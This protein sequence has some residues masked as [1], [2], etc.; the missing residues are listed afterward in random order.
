MAESNRH[1]LIIGNSQ[2]RD[3]TLRQLVTPRL[4]AQTLAHVLQDPAIGDFQVEILLDQESYPL[5]LAIERFFVRS[6]PADTLLLY[7][8]GHGVLDDF[9]R[10]LYLA[11]R[12][13][14]REYLN[15]TS[16]PSG[17]I[18]QMMQKS[19]A[20]QKILILDSCYSGA[21]T[22]EML[23]KGT[24]EIAGVIGSQ[25]GRGV[26]ILTASTALQYAFEGT[27]IEELTQGVQSLFTRFL[28][29]GLK[30]GE[31]AWGDKPFITINDLFRYAETH[32]KRAQV[33]QTPRITAIEQ[34]GDIIIAK[35][36]K[37]RQV[38]LPSG[39]LRMLRS[40]VRANRL[41][42]VDDLIQLAKGEDKA[43][44]SLAIEKLK[45]L[46]LLEDDFVVQ[47]T[48]KGGLTEIGAQPPEIPV[49]CFSSGEQP[50][51]VNDWV[52]LADQHWHEAREF[53]YNGTL[54]KWLAH[55]NQAKLAQ[56][57]GSM[58]KT[59]KDRSLG[60]EHFLRSTGLVKPQSKRDT[61]T[62]LEEIIGR[63]NYFA[64][65]KQKSR[66]TFT[67]RIHHKGRGYLHGTVK[68]NVGWLD[69]PRPNFGCLTGQST[70]VE[71]V[72][73]PERFNLW[74]PALKM[75]LKFSVE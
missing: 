13:T 11:T 27:R 38:V 59:E 25:F 33:S 66:T 46:S 43:L 57:A 61:V 18:R 12:D 63:L 65:G 68:S 58:R 16:V 56:T 17:F 74:R 28:V 7:F 47:S 21:F 36:V 3:E 49:I 32:M 31:A 52:N 26:V 69:V 45:E 37:P 67:L 75:P 55:I 60:L 44:V 8:S 62:N 72:F 35:S 70:T 39:I 10:E 24:S 23:T 9:S 5:R 30:T 51:S 6:R 34:Q 22:S 19:P 54:E 4:D 20:D 1:A 14:D 29:Q 71:V 42:A 73:L 40:P 48:A 15:S 64:L 2:Y 41:A 50:Q 53:L